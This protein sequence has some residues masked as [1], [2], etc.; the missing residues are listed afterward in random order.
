MATQD[1][2]QNLFWLLLIIIVLILILSWRAAS[3]SM[4]SG[5]NSGA[6]RGVQKQSALAKRKGISSIAS[7]RTVNV[8]EEVSR[9]NSNASSPF[10]QKSMRVRSVKKVQPVVAEPTL[11]A[12]E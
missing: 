9:G 3:I 7:K 10:D 5:G 11:D 8:N 12:E 1:V 4:Q 2:R 6:G